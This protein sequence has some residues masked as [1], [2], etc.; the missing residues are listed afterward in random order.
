MRTMLVS[1]LGVLSQWGMAANAQQ[2]AGPPPDLS[3]ATSGY[4]AHP[5]TKRLFFFTSNPKSMG[6]PALVVRPAQAPVSGGFLRPYSI[7]DPVPQNPSQPTL[8]FPPT[9][10]IPLKSQS[11]QDVWRFLRPKNS[12]LFFFSKP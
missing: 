3:A 9:G 5:P 1:V 6:R 2:Q 4:L 11:P 8:K 10:L 7:A 12:R